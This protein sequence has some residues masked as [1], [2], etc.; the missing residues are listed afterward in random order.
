MNTFNI[1]VTKNYKYLYSNL[2]AFLIGEYK[3]QLD[4]SVWV[5]KFGEKMLLFHPAFD[6]DF[7]EMSQEKVRTTSRGDLLENLSWFLLSSQRCQ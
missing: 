7:R 6:V 2:N 3:G 1:L 4:G 5:S